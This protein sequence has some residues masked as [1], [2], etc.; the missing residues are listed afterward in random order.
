[1]SRSAWARACCRV[2]QPAAERRVLN[3]RRTRFV[4]VCSI[5]ALGIGCTKTQ[6]PAPPAA[7]TQAVTNKTPPATVPAESKF[8]AESRQTLR[9][10]HDAMATL[11]NRLLTEGAPS[12]PTEADVS[13]QKTAVESAKAACQQMLLAREA[14]EL[15]LREY[16]NGTFPRERF[17]REFDVDRAK[18]DL[19]SADQA[20]GLTKAR[21]A[22]L[23]PTKSRSAAD[24]AAGR[25]LER[26]VLSAEL[27][28]KKAAFQ[29]EQAQSKL[30]LLVKYD[31]EKQ[32]RELNA[33]VDK[34]RS[35]E[36][37]RRVTLQIEDRKLKRMQEPPEM[38]GTPSDERGRIGAL[39]DE[40]AAI[41]EKLSARLDQ[42]KDG[43]DADPSLRTEI[44]DL[45]RSLKTI[46]R[47]A[48]SEQAAAEFGRL[49]SELRR[50]TAP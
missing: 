11:A 18:A 13:S 12:K 39:L 17:N 22:R 28:Q 3:R 21:Y 23:G 15:A 45:A 43:D 4:S 24:L 5:L 35:D 7:S 20:I 46:I 32:L 19:E 6:A 27:K 44:A 31:H 29:L 42:I 48:Q 37:A 10:I 30:K 1:M 38:S 50:T 41:E 47:R 14:A 8:V 26:E 36:L 2:N 33:R 25:G 9:E 49:K 34:A 40:A 16:E